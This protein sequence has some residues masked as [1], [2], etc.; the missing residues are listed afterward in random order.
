[1]INL[2]WKVNKQTHNLVEKPFANEAEF[3]AYVFG[4]QELLGDV[5]IL[6]R[7][8]RTG[9]KQGIPDMLGVDQDS[10]IC[11]IEMK[12]VEVGEEILPQVLGYAIWA[13]TNPDSIR[14]IW[15]EAKNKPED[16]EIEWD[17]LEVRVIVVAPSFTANLP[18]MAAKVGYP[19]QLVKMQRFSYE[20][21]DEFLLVDFLEEQNL[22]KNSTT[23]VMGD[24]NWDFYEQVHGRE[25][26]ANFRKA[27]ENLDA[28]VKQKN[29]PLSYNLNKYY[30]G[31]KL[32]SSKVVFAVVWGGTHAWNVIAKISEDEAKKFD[33]K[34]WE[35]QRY[36]SAFHQATF[37]PK[38]KNITDITELESLLTIA[39][40]RISGS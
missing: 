5:L 28:F 21:K 15:L 30:T 4:N 20:E 23:K 38:G 7:Q 11:I 8:I 1:M 9:N 10:R 26:V 25:A 32:G 35:F 36:D 16:I 12:N 3:E 19:I 29:W 22:P 39:F 14:A 2:Y 24:W 17:N 31:F 37:R 18:R 13:E 34:N 27:V 33:G 6:H 40:N